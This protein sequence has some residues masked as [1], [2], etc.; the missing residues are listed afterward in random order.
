MNNVHLRWEFN[1][2]LYGYWVLYQV[3]C[4][5]NLKIFGFEQC[6]KVLDNIRLIAAL[7]TGLLAPM[8]F[9]TLIDDS[10]ILWQESCKETGACLVYDNS[11]LSRYTHQSIQ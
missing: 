8:I 4:I 6:R 7:L 9:G 3:K 5:A 11:S 1:G 2:S 10:C